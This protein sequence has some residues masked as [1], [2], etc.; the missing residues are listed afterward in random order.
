MTELPSGEMKIGIAFYTFMY[1]IYSVDKLTDLL[2][3]RFIKILLVQYT[4][5]ILF[6]K[7]YQS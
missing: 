6:V 5:L 3:I 1:R 7:F 2:T 4:E